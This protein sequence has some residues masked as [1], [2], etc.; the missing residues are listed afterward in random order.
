[1]K[2]TKKLLQGIIDLY[3]INKNGEIILV[4]YKTDYVQN[5]NEQELIGKYKEQL[6]IYKRALE[7]ALNKKVEQVY[8][9]SIYLD[10]EIFVELKNS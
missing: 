4:D 8:L 10:K 5:N 9:Y 1:M 3:Y 7:Q 2:H 6:N